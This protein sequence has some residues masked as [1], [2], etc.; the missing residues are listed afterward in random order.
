MGK[1]MTVVLKKPL[2]NDLFINILNDELTKHFGSNTGCKFNTWPSI[3]EE[4]DYMNNH[5]LG[6]VQ[7]PHITRP[8]TKEFLETNFFWHRHGEFS[9][10][11]SSGESNSDE[12]RDAVAICKWI[13]QTNKKYIDTARSFNYQPRIVKDY[14]NHYFEQAGYDLNALWTIPD[15]PNIINHP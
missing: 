1:Y 10:K 9:F 8:V 4:A 2:K 3:E 6:I 11:L 7:S 12:A 13:V 14:L 5:P 15:L